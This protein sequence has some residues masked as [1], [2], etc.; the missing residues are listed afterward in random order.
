MKL[1]EKVAYIK[2]LADGMELDEEKK[3]VKL[4]L[5][6]IDALEEVACAIEDIEENAK[7]LEEELDAVSSDLADV[8]ELV[9]DDD[10]DEDEC[11][12]EH[13]DCFQAKCPKCS[14]IIELSD[15]A[16]KNGFIVCPA[17]GEKLEFET[18]SDDCCCCEEKE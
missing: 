15:E 13:E 10:E 6:I 4:T 17:C 7:A 1:S 14:E 8:E 9:Y 18:C 16:F 12:C 11:E 2:G 5:A 3:E